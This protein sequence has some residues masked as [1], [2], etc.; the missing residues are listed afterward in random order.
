M[1]NS[2]LITIT[3]LSKIYHTGR[4]EVKA[5][6]DVNLTVGKG[7]FLAFSGHSG[8]G[9]TT[10]L[11]LIGTLDSITDGDISF[12]GRSLSAMNEKE[13]TL[14]RRL[15]LGF[16]FQS[17]N[18]IPVLTALENVMLAFEPLGKKD[19]EALGIESEREAS[20]KA[21]EDVG[22]GDYLSRRPG[23]MSGGQ[24]QRVSIA[25]AV[26]RRPLLILCDE[27]T[28]S[29]DSRNSALIL[30]LLEKLNREYGI[31]VIC[32]SHDGDVLEKVRRKVV[33]CDGRVVEDI[34][35]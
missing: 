18:L 4:E 8:S 20:V 11:N 2:N 13:K 27:P 21:L 17:F 24:Q 26:V 15:N 3:H 25:R 28:A 34:R 14:F 30:D 22:L 32:S 29:L 10:L 19:K 35:K 23:E 7:E 33:L 1:T 6:S 12:N 5:L 9:K 31:T 16:V